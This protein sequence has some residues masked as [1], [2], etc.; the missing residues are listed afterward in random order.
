MEHVVV[1][2]VDIVGL[3]GL[4]W[5]IAALAG[6]IIFVLT[7]LTARD[8]TAARRLSSWHI[9]PQVPD[10][11]IAGAV[12]HCRAPRS[13][14]TQVAQQ[15]SKS[16]SAS[17]ACGARLPPSA[18]DHHRARERPATAWVL[19]ALLGLVS[20]TLLVFRYREV[21]RHHLSR[22]DVV[23]GVNQRDRHLVPTGG[24]AGNVRQVARMRGLAQPLH[25][26]RRRPR[27]RSYFDEASSNQRRSFSAP[28]CLH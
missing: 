21:Q 17:R 25:I 16:N 27:V 24:Q 10:T 1:G 20:V 8:Q 3:A 26:F 19:K 14:V 12:N 28:R 11:S 7:E 13:I 23:V 6:G 18:T 15:T 2:C 4:D 5:P 9:G 22:A